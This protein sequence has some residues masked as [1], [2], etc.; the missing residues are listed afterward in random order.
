MN[1]WILTD[2]MTKGALMSRI[3]GYQES[4]YSERF[5]PWKR[6]EFLDICQHLGFKV[7]VLNLLSHI[8]QNNAT[9]P[10]QNMHFVKGNQRLKL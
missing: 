2:V 9:I 5:W 3:I 6:A 4:V 7:N 8:G 10:T 1:G